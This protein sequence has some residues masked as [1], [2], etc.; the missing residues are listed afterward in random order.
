MPATLSQE[1]T[2]AGIPGIPVPAVPLLHV[3]TVAKTL[4]FL[5]GQV[6]YL[7]ERGLT[8][9]S[10]AGEA[11]GLPA[12]WSPA[13]SAV[14]MPRRITPF[15]DVPAIL[16]LARLMRR[17]RPAIVQ[18]HTPKGGL[19]AMIASAITRVPIR[20]F[21]VHGLPH[22]AAK[23]LR[24]ILLS[25]ATKVSCSLAHEVFCVSHSMRQILIEEKLCPA[26]K[27]RVLAN[28][29]AGGIDTGRYNP[30]RYSPA[31]RSECR[32]SL[33]IPAGAAVLLFAG[34]IV[35]DK[36]VV[37]LTLAWQE[38]S[39]RFSDVHLVVAGEFESQDPIPQDVRQSL[40]NDSRVHLV[41][42]WRD[43]PALYAACDVAVL[44]TYR[45][46]FPNVLLEAAAMELPVVATRVPGCT[47]AVVDGVTGVLVPPYDAAALAREISRYVVD[48]ELRSRRGA[49]GRARVLREFQPEVLYQEVHNRYR[50]L[51]VRQTGNV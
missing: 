6:D 7:A 38:L 13:F 51:L 17:I 2:S 35:R 33:G 44:P 21:H 50:A 16:R 36:G 49:A 43:M 34:R 12:G 25:A 19:L 20:I 31:L 18:G 11:S 45:E 28:G 27:A 32:R 8:F 29:S 4:G 22:V 5:Q 39:S 10:A 46:G 14:E 41:G 23:G 30:S 42:V 37:E 3:T 9:Y 15:R 48:P 24:R 47:D 1:T 40:E 26:R